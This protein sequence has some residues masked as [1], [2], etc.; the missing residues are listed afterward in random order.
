MRR[1]MFAIA[2]LL[3]GLPI[4]AQP[5]L[6]APAEDIPFFSDGRL[7]PHALAG[8]LEAPQF[9]EMELNN[10]GL[11]DLIAFDR[12]GS[13]AI[14]FEAYLSPLGVRYRYAP[15]YEP[16]FPPLYQFLQ[17]A[18][19]NCDGLDDL[20]T[21]E[22]L[23]S[24]A[25]VGLKVYLRQAGGNGMPAF[26][27]QML[28]LLS[29]P[30]T[31][32]RIHAFD[33]PAIADINGD[34]LRDIL[35][36]P[37][38]GTQIQYYENISLQLGACDSM[39]FELRDDCWGK[40]SYELDG[41]F[42]LNTCGPRTAGCAGSA[43]LAT[44]S[45]GDGDKDL[46]FSGIYG[47]HI[48]Q[49]INGGS[50]TEA[51]LI[52]QDANWLLDGEPMMEFPAP[53]LAG[54]GQDSGQQ[55][56][57]VATNRLS[58]LGAGPEQTKIYHFI[59]SEE[60][61]GWQFLGDDFLIADMVDHGFRSSPAVW[62]AN[63]D[64]LP[65]MLIGYNKPHNVFG[66]ISAIALY[67]NTGTPTQPAFHLADTDC[68]GLLGSAMKAIHPTFGDLDGDGLAEMVIGLADGRLRTY[69]ATAGESP[70]FIPMEPDPLGG[71][72]LN[73]FAKPQL[74]DVNGDGLPDLACGTRNG[75][76]SLL[77]NEGSPE[78]PSFSLATDTLGG[79]LPMGYFQENSPFLLPAEDGEFWLYN[80]QF[81][82]KA[83]LYKG[84]PGQEFFLQEKNIGPVEVGER[85]AICLHDL[86][87]DQQPELI[88]GNMRGGIGIFSPAPVSSR[89]NA[90][91]TAAEAILYPNPANG[92]DVFLSL[93]ASASDVHVR[94]F[95]AAGRLVREQWAAGAAPQP[96]RF[97]LH[98]LPGGIYM[99]Q[100]MTP[101]SHFT[102]KLIVNQ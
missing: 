100:I 46:F 12:A 15:E 45:D 2:G 83:S 14:P 53:Y 21:M 90:F 6:F 66:Y 74:I 71:F 35:Y 8:G 29:N 76:T 94:L 40:A 97:G 80:G 89:R 57:L 72:H 70:A 52:S 59:P 68:G 32:I 11:T 25:D 22:P 87:G 78:A 99:Y 75:T 50:A 60:T 92:P 54:L 64:G 91:Y 33:L 102:G 13:K 17:S 10:D 63:A 62:D 3:A 16:H 20:L 31:I 44:D 85:A 1:A 24:A 18:D 27:A 30:D 86:N 28:H 4:V 5:F 36:I 41:N 42:M 34:G 82:G 48:L 39:A 51:N 73:G 9:I 7:L 95:D 77:L 69:H 47:R 61:G 67:L 98:G 96:L 26:E 49:L 43:M 81:D 37:Q 58:G 38:G 88:A 93:P 55:S 19:L 79:I 56:L 101:A 23:T 65:D 84:Q